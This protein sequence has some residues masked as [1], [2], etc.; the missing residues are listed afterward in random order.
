M[1]CTLYSARK[2]EDAEVL[3]R[4]LCMYDGDAARNWIGLGLCLE[5]RNEFLL[6]ARSFANAAD[7]QKSQF[8][9]ALYLVAMCCYKM[10]NVQAAKLLAEKALAASGE[11]SESDMYRSLA[12]ELLASL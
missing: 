2:Y 10:Q 11:D 6:A 4:T 9:K 12:K 3:F 5:K 7:L 8:P 1:A